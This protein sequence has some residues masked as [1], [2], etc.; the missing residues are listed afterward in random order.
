MSGDRIELAGRWTR[1]VGGRDIDFVDVPGSYAPL[2]ECVLERQ[3]ECPWGEEAGGR[4]FLVAEG[5]LATAAFSLNGQEVGTAGPWASYRFEMPA[6]LL[7]ACNV[8]RARVRDIT[9]PFGP[10][11]G[12]RFDAGLVRPVRI[13]LRPAVFLE[14]VAFRAEPSEDFSAAACTVAV[15]LNGGEGAVDVLLTERK[16]GRVVG[17][18]VA[19][20][21]AP[22]GFTVEWPRPWS[23]EMPHLYTLT[24]TLRGEPSEVLTEQVGFRRIEAR[25][26]DLYLNGKRL[27]LRGVCR[28]EF[29]DAGGYSPPEA[30]VRR[31]LGMIKHAGFNY[32]RLVHSPHAGCA[33]RIAAE[34]GLL[35]SEEP[36]T[37]WHDLANEAI[38]APA[39]ECLRRT[40]RRDRNVPS[41]FAYL[42]YNECNPSVDYAVKA[43]AVCREL[44]PGCRLGM[45]DCSGRNDEIRAMVAA[46]DLTFYGI[47]A[48]SYWP[49][50]YR[51]RMKAFADRPLV[52]TEWG[53]CLG[54]GNARLLK[55]LCDCFV[56]HSQEREELRVA[57]CSFWAWADYEEHSRPGPAAVEG[58][59]VEGL[60]DAA[61]RPKPDLQALS[62]MCFEM[63]R[64]PLV[65][66]P[67]IEVLCPAP[68]REEAWEPVALD[69]VA[70]DQGALEEAV[71]AARRGYPRFAA[72][73]VP[74]DAPLPGMPRFGRLMVDG[75]EFR[76]RDAAGPAA[77]LLLG[78]GCEEVVIPV[79]RT[80]GAVAAL[81][82]VALRGG[83]PASSVY[84]VH[85]KDAEPAR[86]F[87]APAAEYAFVFEDGTETQPLRHG[88]EILRSNEV[89]RWWTPRP[90]GPVTRPAA[91]AVVDPSYEVLR[92]DL[93][94]R[95]FQGPRRLK[96][97]RWRL[98]DAEAILLLYAVSV[99]TREERGR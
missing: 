43:A 25:G 60:T 11:P 99:Q 59:T 2:G 48:Y 29:T 98:L 80:V 26:Q 20:P 88:I 13:E 1:S 81:G 4:A 55:D 73:S 38:A 91:R 31:E 22:A 35:V 27:L 12:R 34:L 92:L 90:R 49:H 28:H 9:E 71:E 83:Y 36:G 32:V 46:A 95:R 7:K 61:G 52:F 63:G 8:I 54:Q 47:N 77:P 79:G 74:P 93:W 65:R 10:T 42:I 82:H 87:G 58:W 57:G 66:A 69:E 51:E 19:T 14:D 3:F 72:W 17:R 75:I 39:L 67:R 16:T 37:C 96:E 18:G 50:D 15:E 41:V 24:A 45:A 68:R 53:G 76:C 30:E 23:P 40:V 70:T 5:V 89:C 62:A 21:Q 94:E 64:K 84:S 44:D 56:V 86:E 33:S 6:G 85:H 78:R 97:I